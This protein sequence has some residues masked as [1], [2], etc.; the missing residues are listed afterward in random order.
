M[1]VFTLAVVFLSAIA[2]LTASGS[3]SHVLNLHRLSRR[4]VGLGAHLHGRSCQT[5]MRRLVIRTSALATTCRRHRHGHFA[6][7]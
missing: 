5:A 3:V 2:D 6:C 7:L 4:S 1:P